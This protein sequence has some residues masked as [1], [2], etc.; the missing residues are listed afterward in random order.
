[1]GRVN[2]KVAIVTGAG[3]GMG[4][5][6]ALL[7]AKEGAKVVAN[8][9]RKDGGGEET[10]KMIKEAGGDAIYIHADVS[11]AEDVRKL[12]KTTVDTY[13]KL[14]ILVNNAG[15]QRYKPLEELTEDDFDFIVSTNFKGVWLTM[16]YA[17]PEMKKNGK[18]SIINIA[19]ITGDHAQTGST[20]Y[21]GTKGAVLSMTRIAA[22]EFG[23]YNI[24]VNSVQPGVILTPMFSDVMSKRPQIKD[25]VERETPL[26][27]RLGQSV[28]VAPIV[29]FLASDE[30]DFI[31]G[32]KIAVDGG[33]LADSHII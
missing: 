29:V 26:G 2:G 14:D 5:E 9:C 7:F 10:V 6:Q 1:M 8:D 20:I 22:T 15:V 25:R 30:A 3:S 23:L 19:S 31:T 16:K 18:G 11:K 27:H 12:I 13:G 17:L 21:G 28:D 33:I 32:Q 4:R 24:R